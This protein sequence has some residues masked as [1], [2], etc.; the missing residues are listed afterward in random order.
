M[1]NISYLYND[2]IICV[3]KDFIMGELSNNAVENYNSE[4]AKFEW[5]ALTFLIAEDVDIN[6]QILEEGLKKTKVNIL[7]AKNGKEAVDLFS[8]NEDISLV[9]TD[10][11][12]PVM[13]GFD[14]TREMRESNK[15]IPIIAYT[16][17]AYEGVTEKIVLAGAN[18]CLLKPFANKKLLNTLRKYLFIS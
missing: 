5:K 17:Y 11:Q 18:E 4:I 8:K 13:D 7:W 16:A 10:L 9:L 14:S 1:A 12:M 3:I 15:D 6:Y 2:L